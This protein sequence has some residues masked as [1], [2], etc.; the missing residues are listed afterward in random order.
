MS[1]TATGAH[2]IWVYVWE[3]DTDFNQSPGSPSDS[4]HK[5]FGTNETMDSQDRENNPERMFRPFNREAEE[6][7][8]QQ[9][10]GSWSADFTL[11]NTWWLQF[12]FGAP[13]TTEVTAGSEYEHLY[14]TDPRTP[15]KSAHL[16]EETHYP[17]G[18]IEQ[19]V[20]TGCAASSIDVDV[21]TEDTISV[22]L[23]GLYAQDHTF[24][25]SDGDL[26]YGDASD[27]IGSQPSTSYRA[28]HFGNAT[29]SVD[30]DD[31]G[32][33]DMKRLIQDTSISMEGN[34]EGEYEIGSR[35]IAVPSYLQYEPSMDYTGLVGLDIVDG[36][37]RN[38]YGSA[39]ADTQQE[40]MDS[41]QILA[42]LEVD[43]GLGLGD[44]QQVLFEMSG[45]F[46]D[47]YSRNNVGDPQEA[48]E[49]DI[50]RMLTNL[51]VTV[52]T[53]TETAE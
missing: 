19:V 46:P 41:S 5:I 10:D 16:I 28:Q 47:S 35:I 36:E 33:A 37:R 24:L 22:S 13:T 29:L 7:I 23:D 15:P 8:E 11:A 53:D 31:D 3:D 51:T 50:T 26:A 39:A 52:T 12:F 42:Q 30:L 25:G 14:E 20:Y 48:L 1:S 18:Q 43:N 38:A 49:E 27:G 6:I 40:T 21:S 17:G 34:V 2:T 45:A 4:T 32:T 44:Q 9:F